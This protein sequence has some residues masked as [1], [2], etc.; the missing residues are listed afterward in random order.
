VGAA[1]AAARSAVLLQGDICRAELLVEI[2]ATGC[3]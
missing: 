3:A 1:S 2:E